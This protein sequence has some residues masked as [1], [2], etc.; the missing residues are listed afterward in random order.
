MR[1]RDGCPKM[2]DFL[3]LLLLERRPVGGAD[4]LF[5]TVGKVE[6]RVATLLLLG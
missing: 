5:G 2:A 1:E 3:L 4:L 6:E